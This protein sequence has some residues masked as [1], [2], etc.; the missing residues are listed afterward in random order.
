MGGGQEKDSETEIELVARTGEGK[1][2]PPRNVFVTV[3]SP[4]S[5]II[6]W[7]PSLVKNSDHV[8]YIVKWSSIS[9][10]G[11]TAEYSATVSSNTDA[12]VTFSNDNLTDHVENL[13]MHYQI[14]SNKST[15]GPDQLRPNNSYKVWVLAKTKFPGEGTKSKGVI[16]NTFEQPNLVQIP[17]EH[18]KPRSMVVEWTS[19]KEENI[20][21]HEIKMMPKEEFDSLLMFK[22]GFKNNGEEDSKILGFKTL[23][24]NE[25]QPLQTYS[26]KFD[27]LSPG[28]KYV[29]YVEVTYN[30]RTSPND[31][32]SRY[33]YQWPRDGRQTVDTPPAKPLTP[34]SPYDIIEEGIPYLRYDL[35]S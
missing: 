16:F 10:S 8:K 35:K 6:N 24:T 25:T 17:Q 28:T 22:N 5:A 19:P 32:D 9:G 23:Y 15:R 33:I 14:G 18:L 4:E 26:Y 1:P 12:Q 34:G 29:V 27:D 11:D 20:L 21:K 3:L 30:Y 31:E 7:L 13:L 2:S